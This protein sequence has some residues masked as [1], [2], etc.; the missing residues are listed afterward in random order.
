MIIRC[1]FNTIVIEVLF[2]IFILINNIYTTYLVIDNKHC[3]IS[4]ENK[5]EEIYDLAIISIINNMITFGLLILFI[6]RKSLPISNTYQSKP[7]VDCSYYDIVFAFY[8][9]LS[10][11]GSGFVLFFIINY[12]IFTAE[13]CGHT[14]YYFVMI[15]GISSVIPICGIFLFIIFFTVF[16]IPYDVITKM[17][18]APKSRFQRVSQYVQTDNMSCKTFI[19]PTDYESC[20]SEFDTD[21]I[22]V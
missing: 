11:F 22:S 20:E 18:N 7:G 3:I 4:I 16:Y 17:N 21:A 6:I 15:N 2:S 8:C 9:L 13:H 19:F 12:N 5:Y 10:A 1:N 14:F